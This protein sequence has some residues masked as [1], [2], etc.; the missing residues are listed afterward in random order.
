M[1]GL[2]QNL[3]C[4]LARVGI[5]SPKFLDALASL[6]FILYPY[7]RHLFKHGVRSSTVAILHPSKDD[8]N[9]NIRNFIGN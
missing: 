3:I 8:V 5:R 9:M 1:V 6:A 7:F 2:V 4:M